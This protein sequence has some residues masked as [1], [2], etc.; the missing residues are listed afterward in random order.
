M[1]D[2]GHVF[3][4]GAYAAVDQPQTEHLKGHADGVEN[5]QNDPSAQAVSAAAQ[6]PFMKHKGQNREGQQESHRKDA[7]GGEGFHQIF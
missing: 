6:E 3:D 4:Q 7:H 5:A 2:D 1:P